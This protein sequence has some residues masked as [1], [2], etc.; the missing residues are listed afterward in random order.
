MRTV[1][2]ASYPKSGNTWLR[3]LIAALAVPEGAALDINRLR[4]FGGMASDRSLFDAMTLIE[5]GLLTLE[6]ADRLRPLVCVALAESRDDEPNGDGAP[7]VRF[8]K[9]HDGYT[10]LGSGAPLLGG[11]Q[12]ADGAV[13]IVRDP[14]DVA[15]SLADHSGVSLDRAI[16][17]MADPN[18]TFCGARDRQPEQLRQ[19]LLGWSGFAKSW[20]DQTDLPVLLVHYEDMLA[21]PQAALAR[22]LAFAGCPAPPGSVARA[23]ALADFKALAAQEA[24]DGFREAPLRTTGGRFFRRGVAG[25]WRGELTASQVA[26]LEAAHEAM[27]RRLGYS[28]S[29]S[30]RLRHSGASA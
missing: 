3:M 23:A 5:S 21:D 15:T 30:Y 20:L 19:Q 17:D 4:M 6:E 10:R 2:L 16:A 24:L 25:A 12:G 22:V 26:R 18:H 13:L 9:T 1:W 7:P 27:M 28:F 14:R 29:M 11:R 8:V